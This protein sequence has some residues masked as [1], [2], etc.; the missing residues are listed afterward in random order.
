MGE[1]NVRRFL[2]HAITMR[3]FREVERGVVAHTTKSR[4][5]REDG[6]MDDVCYIVSFACGIGEEVWACEEVLAAVSN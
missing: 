1:V 2:R 3:I 5:L 6:A 4:V